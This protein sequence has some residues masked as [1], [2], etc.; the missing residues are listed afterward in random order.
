LEAGSSK[1]PWG[2][3]GSLAVMNSR[4]GEGEGKGS[5]SKFGWKTP[6]LTFGDDAT[7]VEINF[8]L[9]WGR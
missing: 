6:R 1:G 9:V 7:E 5:S 8:G 4:S 2:G 3:E